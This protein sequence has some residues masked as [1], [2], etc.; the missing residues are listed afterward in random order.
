MRQEREMPLATMRSRS[1]DSAKAVARDLIANGPRY[2]HNSLNNTPSAPPQNTV[3]TTNNPRWPVYLVVTLTS[4]ASAYLALFTAALSINA[5]VV[6]L[7][8]LTSIACF[9]L[10]LT[11]AFHR[12]GGLA[13]LLSLSITP[14]FFGLAVLYYEIRPFL[15][16][17]V[18]NAAEIN[19]LIVAKIK[20]P[21]PALE[22]AIQEGSI[23]KA[24]GEDV[25][26][27]RDAYIEKMYVIKNLPVPVTEDALS[28][29][30][31]DI[32]RAYV[33]LK[34]FTYP[35]GLVNEYRVVFFIPTGVPEPSGEIGH[36]A[37]Y[38]FGTLT[39]GCT[40]ARAGGISC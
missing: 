28:V 30:K 36:S 35:S 2:S 25:R 15:I 37:F 31:V 38:D 24:T 16:E 1:N 3:S 11:L 8:I 7:S 32:S 26:A 23:R 17:A 9:A 21:Q 18:Q 27:F 39:T 19:R 4:G 14:I 22:R 10:A 40:V 20:D 34:K 13:F 29:T 6:S 5:T 33:V 12:R